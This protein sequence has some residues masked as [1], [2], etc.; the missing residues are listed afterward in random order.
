MAAPDPAA[1]GGSARHDQDATAGTPTT[2]TLDPPR[3]LVPT[4]HLRSKP[5]GFV[6]PMQPA[7]GRTGA[8]PPAGNA[9]GW[10]HAESCAER[11]LERP[12]ATSSPAKTD[13]VRK[14]VIR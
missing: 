1:L 2:P 14:T 3:A 10:I 7:A 9:T 4:P 8:A 6:A 5:V 12:K 13:G 11:V